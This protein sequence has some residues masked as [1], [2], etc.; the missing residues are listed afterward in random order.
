MPAPLGRIKSL[1]V[2]MMENRSFDH[3]FGRMMSPAYHIDGLTGTESNP[4]SAEQET[5]FLRRYPGRRSHPRPGSSHFADVNLQIFGNPQGVP[6]GGPAMKGF[7][8]SY[9]THT[10]NAAKSRR[11]MKCFSPDKV[12]V[13]TTLAKQYAICDRWF[14]SVPGPT[15]PNRS[16][17]HSATSIGRVD[18]SPIYGPTKRRRFTS[19]SASPA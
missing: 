14:S 6:D 7:V 11:I 19:A 13:L 17:I 1:V 15:L 5:R 8:E 10:H 4:D 16:Y 18:M 12:P 9:Q 2:L 3:M